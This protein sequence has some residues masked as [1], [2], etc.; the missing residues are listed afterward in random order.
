[1]TL[2]RKGN[3]KPEDKTRPG[4]HRRNRFF[5]TVKTKGEQQGDHPPNRTKKKKPGRVK[6]RM[7]VI[8]ARTQGGS[9]IQPNNIQHT[10]H[11]I[12]NGSK[13]KKKRPIKVS[14]NE[15]APITYTGKR[16]GEIKPTQQEKG[17]KERKR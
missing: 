1:M 3:E 10:S 11:D 2:S 4:A 15:T 5:S 8:G 14:K 16:K 12:K 9:K 17:R 7:Y 13:I 6:N